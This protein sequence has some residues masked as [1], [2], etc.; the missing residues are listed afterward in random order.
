M[1]LKKYEEGIVILSEVE[2]IVTAMEGD[3]LK[4]TQHQYL[5][6]VYTNLGKICIIFLCLYSGTIYF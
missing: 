4:S 6:N 2:D 1:N 3:E 5:Y